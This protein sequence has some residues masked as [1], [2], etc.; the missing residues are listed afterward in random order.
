MQWKKRKYKK[1]ILSWKTKTI[2][3]KTKYTLQAKNREEFSTLVK[4]RPLISYFHP[5]Y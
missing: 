2:N 3:S 1:S 5:K 4:K